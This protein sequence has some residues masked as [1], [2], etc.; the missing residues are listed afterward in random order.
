MPWVMLAVLRHIVSI[1]ADGPEI[2]RHSLNG[3]LLVVC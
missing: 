3:V 1:G 2:R